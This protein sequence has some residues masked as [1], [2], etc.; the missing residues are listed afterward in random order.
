METYGSDPVSDRDRHGS[1][2]EL[3]WVWLAANIGIVGV[4]YGA[5]L[6]NLDLWQMLSV[7]V[8]GSALSFLLV[9]VL[10]VAGSRGRHTDAQACCARALRAKGNLGPALVSWVS[11]LRWE[12]VTAVP[13]RSAS[14]W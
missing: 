7:A 12:T 6:T 3:L 10:G 5:I 8:V 4:V 1:A 14:P 9:G 11:L 2:R 13:I